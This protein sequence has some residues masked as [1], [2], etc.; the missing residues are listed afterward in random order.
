MSY[1]T[2]KIHSALQR[3]QR[4]QKFKLLPIW[5]FFLLSIYVVVKVKV[6]EPKYHSAGGMQKAVIFTIYQSE[7]L[8]SANVNHWMLAISQINEISASEIRDDVFVKNNSPK[9]RPSPKAIVSI[10]LEV[11]REKRNLLKLKNNEAFIKM[12]LKQSSY[13]RI[14][15]RA[16][17]KLYGCSFQFENKLKYSSR[18]KSPNEVA[19]VNHKIFA[20]KGVEKSYSKMHNLS[21][22]IL[23][24]CDCKAEKE[25]VFDFSNT[26]LV[27]NRRET[28]RITDEDID[29]LRNLLTQEKSQTT[30]NYHVQNI[31]PD[32]KNACAQFCTVSRP[33]KAIISPHGAQFATYFVS[34]PETKI[35]E[36]IPRFFNTLAYNNYIRLSIRNQWYL[37]HLGEN[38]V[39]E[40]DSN[41]VKGCYDKFITKTSLMDCSSQKCQ[42]KSKNLPQLHLSEL[43][44]R[45]LSSIVLF[46]SATVRNT[47]T[48]QNHDLQSEFVTLSVGG[49]NFGGY[50]R[51]MDLLDVKNSALVRR[52]NAAKNAFS[53]CHL[54]LGDTTNY[55]NRKYWGMKNVVWMSVNAEDPTNEEIWKSGMQARMRKSKN[56]RQLILGNF[57]REGVRDYFS[58]SSDVVSFWIPFLSMN[59]NERQ[60]H[61]PLDLNRRGAFRKRSYSAV[62][63][64][65]KCVPFREKLWDDISH[66]ISSKNSLDFR[67]DALGKCHGSIPRNGVNQLKRGHYDYD[68]QVTTFTK[69]DFV[70]CAE[71]NLNNVGYVTEKIGNAILSG[72]VPIYGGYSG[73]AN[74]INPKRFVTHDNLEELSHLIQNDTKYYEMISE[75]AV[76]EK[77]M[78]EH[79][80]WHPAVISKYSND[81]L[82]RKILGALAHLCQ[83]IKDRI[84]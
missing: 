8:R 48:E 66:M 63:M 21:E 2:V 25:E 3:L 18:A 60:N 38:A 27:Y 22:K 6:N 12:R 15:L 34:H 10:R 58:P 42:H 33:Y 16:L 62:Y 52:Y 81:K 24:I 19:S 73:I 1:S 14:T 11:S 76:S 35:I 31:F 5:A 28:R 84:F 51:L 56:H 82:R 30:E 23:D 46:A 44:L 47:S 65:S 83:D 53:G 71:H 67:L 39:I 75:P 43:D 37:V 4:F 13:V 68:S 69:Y 26:I 7:Y 64:N 79:F 50:Q 40:C 59:F 20:N 49:G 41:I 36:I 61:T 29:G 45:S 78:V 9:Q 54:V 70:A 72:S 77:T 32:E 17:S 80:S 57:W 55:R 74:I